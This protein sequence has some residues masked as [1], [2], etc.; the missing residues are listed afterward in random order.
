[1]KIKI[2]KEDAGKADCYYSNCSCLLATALKRLFPGS[3]VCAGG[4][5]VLVDHEN[6][7]MSGRDSRKFLV[8]YQRGA[9][10]NDPVTLPTF[11]PFTVELK[12]R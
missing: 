2:T 7:L 11:K 4:E 12:K 10:C 5:S 6:F 3:V 8:A 1:M 9:G